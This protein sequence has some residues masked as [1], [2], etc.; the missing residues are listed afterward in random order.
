MRQPVRA[1]SPVRGAL[2]LPK[3]RRRDCCT[4]V[5][6]VLANRAILA[7]FPGVRQRSPAG[8]K[9]HLAFQWLAHPTG[10]RPSL[11]NCLNE[12]RARAGRR[13]DCFRHGGSLCDRAVRACA[14]AEGA[15]RGAGR[16]RR[17]SMRCSPRAPTWRGWCAARCSPPRSRRKALAAVLD[18]R[19]HRRAGRAI[20]S[21]RSPPTGAC[22][23]C[24]TS[25]GTSVRWSPATRAR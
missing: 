16:S 6:H 23:R 14:G 19:R 10:T 25:S 20:S 2:A 4:A 21:R 15:R 5:C 22:S 1:R 13:T 18:G 24:A 8:S 9:S 3:V 17:V 11:L 12:E 7:G